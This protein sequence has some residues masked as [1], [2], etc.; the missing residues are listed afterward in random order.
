MSEPSVDER[1]PITL[2]DEQLDRLA[3]KL[4]QRAAD[5]AWDRFAHFVGRS[6]LRNL[7]VLVGLCAIGVAAWVKVK[8]GNAT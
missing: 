8:T 4:A 1:R 5:A 7:F 3:D 6:V 2:S